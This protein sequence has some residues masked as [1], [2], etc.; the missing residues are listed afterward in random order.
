MKKMSIV[1]MLLV[2]FTSIAQNRAMKDM[3]P[4]QIATLKTKKMTLA[5]DLTDSQQ[6]QIQELNFANA[7]MRKAKRD[8]RK[9]SDTKPTADERYEMQNERLDHQIENKAKMKEI[10][11][12]AQF[13]KWE[14]IQMMRHCGK[15]HKRSKSPKEGKNKG[16]RK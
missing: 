15:K 4:E 7:T 3:T 2:G 9:K 5:L 13:E 10:L 11:S 12:N 16:P 1:L 8:E 14:K 6:A